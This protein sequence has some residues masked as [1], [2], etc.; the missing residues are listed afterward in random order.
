M[1][2]KPYRPT[3]SQLRTFVTI[4]EHGH[5]GA[6]AQRLGI[7]QPS[8]SQALAALENGL[9]VQLIERSTRRVIVTP[10]GS[11]LLPF[12]Q[13]TVDSLDAFVSH[14]KGAQGHLS[15]PV[16]I[17]M[18]PTIAPFILPSLLRSLP[19]LAPDMEPRIV[20]EKTANLVESLRHGGLDAAVLAS[21]EDGSGLSHIDLYHEEFVLVVPADH[22]YAGRTDLTVEDLDGLEL[23]L[24]DDGHCL[25]D[26]VLDLCRSSSLTVEPASSVTRAASL[27][28]I[29]QCVIGGL[30]CTL[31]PMSAVTAECDRPGL[32][33]ARFAGGA[34][35]AGRTVSL[36]YRTSSH[37][38]ED[39][40]VLADAVIAAYQESLRDGQRLLD[41]LR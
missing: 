39:F 29:V 3:I 36:A 34:R 2:N 7:S 18:I 27:S 10:V 26:Q 1:V 17:G 16:S 37:R 25:R 13:A 8:L 38:G 21:P 32:G 28:T 31:V 40:S 24:L 6:A 14:A 41:T 19:G 11:S 4:A 23:L 5:F 9:G 30:G 33:L 35:S 20:E 15:G 22:D 12:A